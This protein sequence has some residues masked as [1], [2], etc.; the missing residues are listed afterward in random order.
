MLGKLR[1]HSLTE[2]LS[3]YSTG[4]LALTLGVLGRREDM[5]VAVKQGEDP[6]GTSAS[7]AAEATKRLTVQLLTA[8]TAA[9]VLWAWLTW[10]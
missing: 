3:M 6:L 9:F 2:L 4:L 8:I 7:K 5:R 10:G 1:G